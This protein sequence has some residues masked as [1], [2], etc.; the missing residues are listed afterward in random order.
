MHGLL[1]LILSLTE[2]IL[3][4]QRYRRHRSSDEYV[5]EKDR[6]E[7]L[8]I[9]CR[10][11]EK[12]EVCDYELNSDRISYSVY[13]VE[14]F[15]RTFPDDELFLLIGSDMLLSFEKWYRFEDIMKFASICVVSRNKGDIGKLRKKA[16]E[17]GNSAIFL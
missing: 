11:E 6:L 12:L 9:V 2:F 4:R 1:R 5:P 16:A 13:T 14:Y 10:N 17:L 15:R 8:R 7:M 3:F